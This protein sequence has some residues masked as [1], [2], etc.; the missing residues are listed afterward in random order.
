MAANNP[1]TA[2]SIVRVIAVT[3]PAGAGKTALVHALAEAAAGKPVTPA[4]AP[5]QSVET[6]LSAFDFMGDRYVMIDAPGSADFAADADYA[7]PAADLAIVVAD[8]DPD[9]AD[10]AQPYLHELERQG[11]PHVLLINKVDQ[12][13][14]RIL[15]LLDAFQ[16]ISRAPLVARQI[17]I[18]R[19][20]KAHGFVDL[21]LERAYVY[22]PGQ[23]SQRIDIPADLVEQETQARFHLLEQLADYDDALM[24]QLLS[25]A[26]PSQ[27][28]V[29]ADLVRETR[30]GLITPVFFGSAAQGFGL[31][32]LLK[33]LRHDT[34][35]PEVAAAR[36]GLE[37]P[38]VYVLK[39]SHA[40]QAGKLAY[41]RVLAGPLTEAS[42]LTLSDGSRAR[43]G[44][45][46]S[47]AGKKISEAALGEIAAIGKIDPVAAGDVLA[48]GGG[49]HARAAPPERFPVYERAIA[50]TDRKDDVRLSGALAKLGEEDPGLSVLHNAETH[51]ILL[52]GQ[53]EP[54]L[55][56]VL[57]KLR[58]RFAV[59]VKSLLPATPYKE[60]IRK[61]AT[62]RGRHKKQTGGHGQFADVAIE[63]RPLARGEGFRFEDRIAGGV[64]PRQWIPAVE[65]GVR[66]AME[67]GPLGFPVVDVAVTLFDGA[68]HSVDSSE[69]AFRTA[70][71]IAMSE[72]L[73]ACDP[74]PLEPI[75][76]LTVFTPAWGTPKINSAVSARNG[77]ILGFEPRAEWP[78]WDKIEIYL[79]HAERHDF[80]I[81]LRSLT[82]G[83]AT[84]TARF[85]HMVEMTGRRAAD[86][87]RAAQ[88]AA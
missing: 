27:D 9:R 10:L 18:W 13:E 78:G 86:A 14:G 63:I 50:T 87:R 45:L 40:G 66:D 85:S 54:H 41:A 83:L 46:F 23:P 72:G 12:A 2:S 16:M 7:L 15:D 42:E 4:Q 68:F 80:I 48:A 52:R 43:A 67:A 55:R 30:E 69:L 79:P 60:T 53:G 1:R 34:P 24:E 21:A 62:Q 88:P 74:A 73:A 33:A 8:P 57:E 32:R 64:V 28:T 58:K 70:G 31:R 37:T 20:D 76:A 35:G 56:L 61:G 65:Q 51:E 26:V 11:V 59:D 84:F 47:I 22:R 77:Q 82:Q 3:G 25:D 49:A 29:F 71:R 38:G 44:A 17:P 5:G 81:E 39:I 19:D 75:D 6:G 36:L